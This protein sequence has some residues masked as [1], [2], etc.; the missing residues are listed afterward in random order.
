MQVG[1][2]ILPSLHVVVRNTAGSHAKP[3]LADAQA[4]RSL[5]PSASCPQDQHRPSLSQPEMQQRA[6]QPAL[7]SATGVRP[8]SEDRSAPSAISGSPFAHAN[9]AHALAQPPAQAPLPPLP[10]LIP[11]GSLGRALSGDVQL[12]T[13]GSGASS[14]GHAGISH[15]PPS[16]HPVYHKHQSKASVEW[17][18]RLDICAALCCS[19]FWL[20]WLAL[21]KSLIVV[22]VSLNR[23]TEWPAGRA[24]ITLCNAPAH[25]AAVPAQAAG[26]PAAWPCECRTHPQCLSWLPGSLHFSPLPCVGPTALWPDGGM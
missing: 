19:M 1:A 25:S 20:L 26:A 8:G 6:M 17:L 24:S 23:R 18:E 5:S 2:D 3:Q 21:S 15:L 14:S 12:Q 11:L 10:A 7:G 9:G 13:R 16:C 22:L 4:D